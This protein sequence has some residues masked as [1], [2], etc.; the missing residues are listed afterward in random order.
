MNIKKTKKFAESARR[1]LKGRFLIRSDNE[2]AFQCV[3]DLK[4]DLEEYFSHL[5]AD[6]I[7]DES[8]GIAYL[9]ENFEQDFQVSF[10]QSKTL[11]GMETLIVIF[12]RQRRNDYLNGKDIVNENV[13]VSLD[14]IRSF[15]LH[16]NKRIQEKKFNNGEFLPTID[17]LKSKQFITENSDHTYTVTPICEIILPHDEVTAC[18]NAA[19]KYFSSSRKNK[20]EQA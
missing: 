3:V 14:E 6:F 16:F 13:I 12:L 19:E 7:L 11:T 9:K 5:G 15:C 1:L 17:S 18:L 4:Y 20:E 2:T 8:Q 10:G